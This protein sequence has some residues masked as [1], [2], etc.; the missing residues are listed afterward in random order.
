MSRTPT[1][2]ALALVALV[3]SRGVAVAGTTDVDADNFR[4][5]VILCENAVAHAKTCCPNLAAPQTACVYHDSLTTTNCGCEQDG[6]SDYS[7][8]IT[9][10]VIDVATSST[11]LGSSCEALAADDGCARL[12]TELAKPNTTTYGGGD[13]QGPSGL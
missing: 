2:L 11:I 9:T 13:C 5:D 4:E 8:Q 12:A 10:P 1:I 3:L 7:G 6:T